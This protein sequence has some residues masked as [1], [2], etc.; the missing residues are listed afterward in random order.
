MIATPMEASDFY[1]AGGTL[2][3]GSPSYVERPADAELYHRTL[4]GEFCYVLTARQMG[5]SSL[6]IRTAQRLKTQ[7]VRSA[8]VDLNR[9]GT[10][11]SIE[12]WYLGLLSQLKRNLKLPVDLEDWWQRQAVGYVQRFT[13]FLHDIVLQNIEG[14]VVIFIDEIDSTLKLPFSDDFFAAI[15]GL[16]NARATDPNYERLVFVLLGVATPAELIKDPRRTPFNIGQAVDLTDFSREDAQL[17]QQGLIIDH[18]QEGQA[19]FDRI[20]YW[21]NGHPYLTQ[22]LCLEVVEAKD[23]P[24][25]DERVDKLVEKLFLT[26]EARK[27]TNLKFIQDSIA[28]SPQRDRHKLLTLYR[29]VYT[30]KKILEDERS[31]EQNRLRLFG[32][33]RVKDG[34]LQT[35]NEI[36]R[37]V[38]DLAWIK[39]HTPVDWS[40]WLIVLLTFII[41]ALVSG[42]WGYNYWQNRQETQALVDQFRATTDPDIRITSLANLFDR[43]AEQQARRLFFEDLSAEERPVL[44]NW[45]DPQQVGPQMITAIKGLYTRLENSEPNNDLL[46][47]MAKPLAEIKNDARAETLAQEIA[48]WLK[49]REFYNQGEYSL[50]I[51]TYNKA[52]SLNDRNAG[53]YFDRALAYVALNQAGPALANFEQVLLLE[54]DDTRANR[55]TALIMSDP[56]LYKAVGAANGQSYPAIVAIVPTPTP[57]A[58][59]TFTP[60][61]TPTSTATPTP[62]DTPTPPASSTPVE[63]TPV[64]SATDTPTSPPTPTPSPT[65]TPTPQPA[66][67]VYVQSRGAN[68]DLGLVSSAG[69]LLDA[70]LHRLAAAPAWSPD[71]A[72]VAFYGEQGISELGGVYA[73]GNGIWLIDIQTRTP[74]LLFQIDH[75]KNVTWSLDGTK[76]A[77]EFGPPYNT[78]HAVVIVDVRNGQE[79]NRFPGEQPAW[80]PNSAELVIKS[81]QPECGLWQVGGATNKLLTRDPTDSYPAI[82][83]DGKYMVFS[84]RFRDVDWEI[85]RFNLQDQAE[86]IL[87]LTQRAGTDTTP[88]ISPDGLEIYLRTDAFGDWQVTAMTI[89][90]KNERLIKGN[91]GASEDWG[92][93]RPA[94]H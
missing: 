46:S 85:Y 80:L 18:P 82:S 35:R 55:I 84:S 12:H 9:L 83:P 40:R 67:I 26:K 73:Q 93:A 32:L 61:P 66:T 2:R 4:A 91:I 21:T 29:Q 34:I 36:Y 60:T 20:Y 94:V 16:Y 22:K 69:Q 63:P 15:R 13:D 48:Q 7:G 57:T 75:V 37:Q 74:R 81:C 44:F 49:G 19:I 50:A 76:L 42:F 62:T 38:F 52:I 39:Q 54:D 89:D 51:D 41:I 53:V 47:T 1:V 58:T 71:G 88:V 30:G 5:K 14:Q 11:I 72:M 43:G 65:L 92:L 70:E 59:P 25:P 79:L 86:E 64:L 68:H 90:G 77:F 23:G 87:R 27:E 45:A 24:W 78:T 33:V 31:L 17:L 28:N 8:I 10:D 6:M 56:L 3:P